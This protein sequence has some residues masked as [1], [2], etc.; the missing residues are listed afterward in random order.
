[1]GGTFAV[2]PTPSTTQSF[3]RSRPKHPNPKPVTHPRDSPR[4]RSYGFLVLG[5]GG[6]VIAL[7]NN[8]RWLLCRLRIRLVAF[9][10]DISLSLPVYVVMRQSQ[11]IVEKLPVQPLNIRPSLKDQG[12][13]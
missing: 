6:K 8:A 11:E 3:L 7:G 10:L 12:T 4:R 5:G 1:M 2:P 9:G 13:Q